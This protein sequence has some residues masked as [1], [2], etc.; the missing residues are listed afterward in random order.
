V[1]AALD[2]A[3]A[4]YGQGVFSYA[5]VMAPTE[6]EIVSAQHVLQLREVLK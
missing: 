6:G 4:V 1:I 2:Q 3:R 5:G